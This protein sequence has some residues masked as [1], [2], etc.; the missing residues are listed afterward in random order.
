MLPTGVLAQ[1]CQWG[2]GFLHVSLEGSSSIQEI[3]FAQG[4]GG[5]RGGQQEE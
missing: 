4:W 2:G 5:G 1:L 3:C